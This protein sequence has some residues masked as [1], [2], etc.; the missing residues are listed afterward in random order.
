MTPIT[1][2][3]TKLAHHLL[4]LNQQ[5]ATGELIVEHGKQPNLQ[6]HIYFYLGRVV[7]ATGGV[8]PV[9]RWYRA[10]KHDCPECF[11][12]NWLFQAQSDVDLW[13]VDLL[14]QALGQG[15]IKL[16]Q[17]KAVVQRIVQEVMFA[18]MGQK[19]FTTEWRAGYQIPQ[20]FT[21]LSVEQLVTEAQQMREQWRNAGLGFLQELMSQ[22]SPDLAPVLRNRVQIESQM[23]ASPYR[24][25]FK[26]MRGQHSLWDISV[27]MERPLP[28]ILQALLPWIH[29]G[30]IELKEIADLP[31][32]S[33]KPI[34]SPEPVV[35]KPLIACVDGNPA[36]GRTIAQFL[37]PDYEVIS[38][39][40]PLRGIG[41][42]LERKPE[43]IFL[44]PVLSETNGYDFC[45]LLRK[46]PEL[47]Q[48]PIV[49]MAHQD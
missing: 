18:L 36:I 34:A 22:F 6:W 3:M 7:Y 39:F 25:M 19:F 13:E 14:N 17:Y 30:M 12:A 8:H 2:G 32:L 1:A 44:N 29:R 49:M 9:R 37:Q 38:I 35:S 45:A 21:L 16:S 27:E 11:S 48:T 42:L 20:Q 26:L 10:F 43:L 41:T 4:L 46:T 31:A 28:V 23:S 47:Q 5:Q 24:S 33:S 15:H 40:N